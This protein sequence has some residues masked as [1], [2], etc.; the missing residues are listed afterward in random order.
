MH[1][2]L[3]NYLDNRTAF[4]RIGPHVGPSFSIGTGVMIILRIQMILPKLLPNLDNHRFLAIQT[5]RA[6]N[7]VNNFE[8]LR[9]I[10]TNTSKFKIINISRQN[11]VEIDTPDRYYK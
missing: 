6:I 2:K 8:K 7:H 1:A 4:I 9:K 10:R 11:T 3:L 5:G